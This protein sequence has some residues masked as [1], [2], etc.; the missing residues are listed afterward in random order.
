MPNTPLAWLLAIL[1]FL[2]L[3][4]LIIAVFVPLLRDAGTD[5]ALAYAV[6]RLNL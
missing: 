1:V 5:G 3:A 4:W 2:F 6:A